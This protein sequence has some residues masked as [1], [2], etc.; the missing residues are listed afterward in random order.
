VSG[1]VLSGYGLILVVWGVGF[2]L[3]GTAMMYFL[4]RVMAADERQAESVPSTHVAGADDP[5]SHSSRG[6]A[7]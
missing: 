4:H 6:I 7:A 1:I 2:M 3:L 5:T